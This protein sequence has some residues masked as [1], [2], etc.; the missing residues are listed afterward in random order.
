MENKTNQE[1][2][3]KLTA[4]ESLL[5][6]THQVKPRTL[7]EAAKFLDLSPSH[8]YKLTSERKIPH[9]KPNGKKIYFDES[10]LV[11]WLKRN[12]AR[13]QEETEEKAASYIV[14]GKGQYETRFLL[15]LGMPTSF[16]PGVRNHIAPI[17][18]HETP[19]T[20]YSWGF[21]VDLQ[22]KYFMENEMQNTIETNPVIPPIKHARSPDYAA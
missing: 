3:N 18:I 11:Q 20:V 16:T 1:I 19:T 2:F 22:K 7:A 6:G 17:V 12:P 13:T 15:S 4:I 8:L 14:S 10:E 9:F 21:L 5:E